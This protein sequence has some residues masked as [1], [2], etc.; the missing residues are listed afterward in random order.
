MWSVPILDD[1]TALEDDEVFVL[2]LHSSTSGVIIDTNNALFYGTTKITI[3]DDDSKHK[4]AISRFSPQH[5]AELEWHPSQD[6]KFCC[7]F[8]AT[9]KIKATKY[10]T[11][12]MALHVP[13]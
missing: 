11:G 8:Y 3:V 4:L 9:S 7:I 2:S 13:L 10:T 5:H 12:C 1:D 6:Q